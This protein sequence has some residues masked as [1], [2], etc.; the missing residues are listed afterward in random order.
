MAAVDL[1]RATTGVNLPPAVASE[2]WGAT[3][4]DSAVMRASRQINLPGS[5][6]SIPLVTGEP[7]AGWVTESDE[8][9]VSR[10]TLSNKTMTPYT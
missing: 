1:N 9:P 3:V 8:K 4:E 10:A 2:I 6:I 5:G 7:T